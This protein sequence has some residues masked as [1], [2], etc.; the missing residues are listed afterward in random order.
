MSLTA[1]AIIALV[2]LGLLIAVGYTVWSAIER[3][4]VRKFWKEYAQQKGGKYKGGIFSHPMLEFEMGGQQV[5]LILAKYRKR[6]DRTVVHI[7]LPAL[8]GDF[9]IGRLGASHSVGRFFAGQK[10][11]HS[12]PI[13]RVGNGWTVR[14]EDSAFVERCA[15]DSILVMLL[16]ELAAFDP[17]ACVEWCYVKY[18]IEDY[19]RT[20]AEL[21][22]IMKP[23]ASVAGVLLAMVEQN[24]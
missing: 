23:G 3:R 1:I 4:K 8:P 6:P 14:G 16:A 20:E 19:A 7:H 21:D 18:S 2:V 5:R 24:P 9:A 13:D 10:G 15:N 17:Q 12:A 11:G 22:A